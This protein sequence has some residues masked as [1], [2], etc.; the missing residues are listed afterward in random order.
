MQLEKMCGHVRVAYLITFDLCS[1]LHRTCGSTSHLKLQAMHPDSK[2]ESIYKLQ[3]HGAG[4]SLPVGPMVCTG[5][6]DMQ[7]IVCEAPGPKIFQV[8]IK[9]AMISVKGY[10]STETPGCG[11]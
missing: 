3:L 9:C 10:P 2:Q 5:W 8:K 6:S 7:R 11:D 4:R 1:G